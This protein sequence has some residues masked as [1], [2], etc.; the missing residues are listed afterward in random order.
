MWYL[1]KLTIHALCN[2]QV[3]MYNTIQSKLSSQVAN[4][5]IEIKTLIGSVLYSVYFIAVIICSSGSRKVLS[6]ITG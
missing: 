5:N 4:V 2:I 3:Y 6:S 1:G